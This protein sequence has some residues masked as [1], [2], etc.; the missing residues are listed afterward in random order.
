M[1]FF[2]CKIKMF[3]LKKK[4]CATLSSGQKNNCVYKPVIHNL[5]VIT[6]KKPAENRDIYKEILLQFITIAKLQL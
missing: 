1:Y 5:C 2:N 3:K 6:S 4:F